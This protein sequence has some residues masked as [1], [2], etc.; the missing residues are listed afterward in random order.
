[1]G[2][3]AMLG[4]FM[5]LQ[6]QIYIFHNRRIIVDLSFPHGESVNTGVDVDS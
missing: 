3:N 4:H 6:S 5:N 1:M 2:F